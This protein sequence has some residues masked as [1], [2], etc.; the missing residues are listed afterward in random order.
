MVTDD[1]EAELQSRRWPGQLCRTYPGTLTQ[2]DKRILMARD[3]AL[4]SAV[5]AWLQSQIA[6]G[7]PTRMLEQAMQD[8]VNA[9]ATR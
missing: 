4:Q 8:Y 2:G 7:V 5:E 1:V 9:P 3:P 6:A